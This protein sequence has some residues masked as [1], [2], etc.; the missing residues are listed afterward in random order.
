MQ[1]IER[2]LVPALEKTYNVDLKSLGREER[3]KT[4]ELLMVR[5]TAEGVGV[6][7]AGERGRRAGERWSFWR[8]WRMKRRGDRFG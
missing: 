3:M 6:R 2:Y 5:G 1:C 4:A 7:G 8:G